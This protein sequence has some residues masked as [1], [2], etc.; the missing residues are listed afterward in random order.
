MQQDRPFTVRHLLTDPHNREELSD[1]MV[2]FVR[3]GTQNI[4]LPE[5]DYEFQPGDRVLLAGSSRAKID[6]EVG[7]INP[8]ELAYIQTGVDRSG[9]WLCGKLA[10]LRTK[11]NDTVKKD[12]E[13]E[14]DIDEDLTTGELG[15]IRDDE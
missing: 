13:D 11:K 1:A 14:I 2:L 7:L 6:T 4:V 12:T 15:V 5:F 3:R 9:G 8:M 10:G